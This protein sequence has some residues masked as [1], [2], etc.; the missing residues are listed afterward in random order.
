MIEQEYLAFAAAFQAEHR[1]MRRLVQVLRH[2]LG[3]PGGWSRESAE[4]AFEAFEALEAHLKEH[5]AQEEEGGYLEQALAVAP[6]YSDEAKHLLKQHGLMTRQVA[7]AVET[8]KRRPRRARR[9]D[10][11]GNRGSRV[12]AKVGRTRNGRK[13]DRAKGAEH[14]H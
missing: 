12:A 10:H 9:L 2:A 13:S 6:R 4:A 5:F 11:V 1:E 14:R 8:A 7:H 3:K